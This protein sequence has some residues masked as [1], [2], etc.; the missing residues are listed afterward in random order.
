MLKKITSLVAAVVLGGA[1]TAASAAG[2]DYTTL[3]TGVDFSSVITAIMAIAVVLMGLYVARSGVK[4]VIN[5]VKS[6]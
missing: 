2:P 5:M 1:A 6:A 3:T 4:F